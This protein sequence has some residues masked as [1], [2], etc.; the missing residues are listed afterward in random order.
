MTTTLL[1]LEHLGYI[2]ATCLFGCKNERL[3]VYPVGSRSFAAPNQHFPKRWVA[4]SIDTAHLTV[5]R[6]YFKLQAILFDCNPGQ[7]Y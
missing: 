5:F 7:V 1:F 4:N 2:R 3:C 6:P